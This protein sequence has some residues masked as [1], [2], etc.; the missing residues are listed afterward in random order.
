M[1]SKGKGKSK[2]RSKSSGRG[3]AKEA[4]AM[5][6]S[7]QSKSKAAESLFRS[8][9]EALSAKD[10]E[11]AVSIYG[12][13]IL[14]QPKDAKLFTLRAAALL[15]LGPEHHDAASE[16]AENAL[17][18]EPMAPRAHYIMG[19][20][21]KAKGDLCTAWQAYQFAT[22]L[23]GAEGS[24]TQLYSGMARAIETEIAESGDAEL[25]TQ[26]QEA[27]GSIVELQEMYDDY[28]Q[29]QKKQRRKMLQLFWLVQS[30]CMKSC[31][32]A[33][34]SKSSRRHCIKN[35]DVS[36]WNSPSVK[37]RTRCVR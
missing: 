29:K 19:T 20:V 37:D 24:R 21:C 30:C 16:D 4:Q 6:D 7:S 33:G 27:Q 2:N 5:P 8:S 32:C 23:E 15:K 22:V 14:L 28:V 36:D 26:L 34:R 12:K 13:A 17:A 11:R 18:L 3:L 25:A 35:K 9:V 31:F 1:P 10:Y